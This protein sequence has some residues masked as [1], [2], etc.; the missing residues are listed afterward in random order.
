MSNEVC[1]ISIYVP[2]MSEAVDFYTDTLGFE[3]N[4]EYGPKIV[5]L[6]HGELPIVLEENENATYRND[7]K[8]TGIALGLK[9]D[10]IY[11][12]TSALKRKRR[13]FY[14]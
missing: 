9:T 12:T 7:N 10:D 2:N 3:V 8:T 6:V 1:V 11:E 14:R 4:K 5:S 13:G